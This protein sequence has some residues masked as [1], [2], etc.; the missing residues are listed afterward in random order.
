[1]FGPIKYRKGYKYQL[2]HDVIG[3]TPIYA[4]TDINTQFIKLT[5]EGI[6]TV[7]SGYSW[8]GASGPT[9]NTGNTM[10]PSLIHDAFCQLIRNGFLPDSARAVADRFFFDML[11]ARKMWFVRARIWYRGVRIGAQRKQKPKEVFE[12]P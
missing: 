9:F 8:D 1:M 5:T 10:T 12:A 4:T 7:K 11:R 6:M 2:A 3:V